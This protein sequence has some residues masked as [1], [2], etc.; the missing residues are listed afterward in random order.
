MS[1]DGKF[2]R[3][4]ILDSLLTGVDR[5]IYISRVYAFVLGAKVI[6]SLFSLLVGLYET[7]KQINTKLTNKQ[8]RNEHFNL[9]VK[10]KMHLAK[11]IEVSAQGAA[12][13]IGDIVAI[14]L[15]VICA[16]LL[17]AIW[18]ITRRGGG[19]SRGKW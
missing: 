4:S 8:I 7:N 12:L 15:G 10:E 13:S 9:S 19:G 5:L 3:E 16:A 6:L 11:R 2:Q 14:V 17:I 18:C 1:L